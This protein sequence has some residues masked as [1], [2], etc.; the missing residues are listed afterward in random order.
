[1]QQSV[2]FVQT[3]DRVRIAYAKTGSGPAVVKTPNWLTH[4]EHD[5]QSPGWTHWLEFLS[6]RW[7]LIRCDQRGSG[8]SDW[9]VDDLSFDRWVDDL[10][11]VVDAAGLERFTLLGISQGGA[12]AVEYAARHPERV[13]RLVLNGAYAQGWARRGD[14]AELRQGN[15]MADLI[16]TGWGSGKQAFLQLFTDLFMPEATPEQRHWFNELQRVSTR[17]EIAA[18]LVRAAG[19]IDIS[20]RLGDVQV[21]TLVVHARDDARVP[22]EQGRR[23]A[24]GIPGARLVSLDTRNH[25]L[26]AQDPAWLQFCELFAEFVPGASNERHKLQAAA[27]ELTTRERD[28]VAL[29]AQGQ[30]NAAIA[31]Q[32]S[33][34]AKT[35]RNHLSNIFSKLGVRTRAELIVA[36]RDNRLQ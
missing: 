28:I 15:A 32:M 16:E 10:E 8:L 30:S 1:M 3:P 31:A 12:V 7:T 18:R 13:E 9:H 14:A 26:L 22:F 20:D 11:C 25:V 35:V 4:L 34:T 24:A 27:R 2:H 17:P 29:V 6:S 19:E 33:I 36:C 23:L 5:A 21:P